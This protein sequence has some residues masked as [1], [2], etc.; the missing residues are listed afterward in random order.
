MKKKL[1]EDLRLRIANAKKVIDDEYRNK[2]GANAKE[3]DRLSKSAKVIDGE[4]RKLD[5]L[6]QMDRQKMLEQVGSIKSKEQTDRDYAEGDRR[7]FE[8]ELEK[9]LDARDQH[10]A[11]AANKL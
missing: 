3:A 11:D 2:E 6:Y 9:V 5:D 10:D 4:K 8:T 7:D 1:D